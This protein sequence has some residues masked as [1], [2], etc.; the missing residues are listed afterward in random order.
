MYTHK[1]TPC[2]CN[3][4]DIIKSERQK[5][6]ELIINLSVELILF[7]IRPV[8]VSLVLSPLSSM[9]IYSHSNTCC[10]CVCIFPSC[11]L[12]N[13]RTVLLAFVC[14]F[15]I[16][17]NG[18]AAYENAP[19]LPFCRQKMTVLIPFGFIFVL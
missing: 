3:I 4:S 16:D 6:S 1:Y 18:V 12:P 2:I 9:L 14:V 5:A 8:V 15:I 10:T 11:Q 7:F 17:E 19:P 13:P